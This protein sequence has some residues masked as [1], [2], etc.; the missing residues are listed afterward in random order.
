[1]K[2][3]LVEL[4]N[5]V[6]YSTLLNIVLAIWMMSLIAFAVSSGVRVTVTNNLSLREF[7]VSALKVMGVV[8]LHNFIIYTVMTWDILSYL[9]AEYVPDF[10]TR[11]LMYFKSKMIPL[12]IF[13]GITV[14]MCWLT[15]RQTRI[16]VMLVRAKRRDGDFD[17]T[18]AENY[19]ARV[20]RAIDGHNSNKVYDPAHNAL[21]NRKAREA[22][23]GGAIAFLGS[24]QV[25]FYR[26]DPDTLDMWQDYI[27]ENPKYSG[28]WL[29]REDVTP[30]PAP[31]ATNPFDPPSK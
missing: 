21:V 7:V 23:N 9:N 27:G 2:T 14:H 10:D 6:P 31:D 17:W 24:V 20:F 18:T 11:S 16:V 1:M 15:Y 28:E 25:I 22:A 26:E 12:M 5:M 4:L 8:A 30:P 13:V 29:Q 19:Q 3:K